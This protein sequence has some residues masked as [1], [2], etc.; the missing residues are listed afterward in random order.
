MVFPLISASRYIVTTLDDRV[1]N[2]I[3]RDRTSWSRPEL[4]KECFWLYS[5]IP[6][7]LVKHDYAK[8][9]VVLRGVRRLERLVQSKMYGIHSKICCIC[10]DKLH[11]PVFKHEAV[12]YHIR[13]I[14]GWINVA[15]KFTDPITGQDYTDKELIRIDRTCR[16]YG[17]DSDVYELRHDVTRIAEDQD[18]REHEERMD[19]LVDMLDRDIDAYLTMPTFPHVMARTVIAA[20]V[21]RTF[22]ELA[23][24]DTAFAM[25]KINDL[26]AMHV[27]NT[28]AEDLNKLLFQIFDRIAEWSEEDEE[29]V[30]D[31]LMSHIVPVLNMLFSTIPPS[32]ESQTITIN[33][34]QSSSFL[35]LFHAGSLP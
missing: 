16:Q 1:V 24:L 17:I 10:K 4:Q 20:H 27:E 29:D 2:K 28:D 21:M 6:R 14:L 26:I 19:I 5:K 25:E 13:C 11:L 12:G 30:A 23:H 8:A 3:A 9:L 32:L 31:P 15:H 34:P 33:L 22:R 7:G 35:P 18:Q